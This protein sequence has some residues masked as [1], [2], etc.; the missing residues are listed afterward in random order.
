M[1]EGCCLDTLLF[2]DVYVVVKCTKLFST[3]FLTGTVT[4]STQK[5]VMALSLPSKRVKASLQLILSKN[6]KLI[7]T[8]ILVLW[9]QMLL[10]CL[11]STI[12][13]HECVSTCKFDFLWYECKYFNISDVN[14]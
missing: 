1:V 12:E 5:P 3:F 9:C 13:I 14:L 6:F 11:M 10:K 8:Y 4:E 2:R 7:T